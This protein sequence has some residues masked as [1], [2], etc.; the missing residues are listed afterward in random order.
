MP[1]D[2]HEK[3]NSLECRRDTKARRRI[4]DNPNTIINITAEEIEKGVTL[5]QLNEVNTEVH[6]YG[7]QLTIHGTMPD[8]NPNARVNGYKFLF[9]NG[10]GSIGVKY[11]AVDGDKK[12]IIAKVA[13]LVN[14]GWHTHLNSQGFELC[15]NFYVKDET[16]R[17]TAKDNTIAAMK[18]IP[19]D[20]FFGSIYAYTL[21]Y[22]MGYG[23]CADI[24]AIPE[25]EL[26]SFIS[27][28]FN[29]DETQVI[30]LERIQKEKEIA[31]NLAYKLQREI[32]IAAQK[33]K[34]EERSAR[35]KL[36]LPT[37]TGNKLTHI[38]RKTEITFCGYSSQ[39]E[40][41][42]PR[43]WDEKGEVI[44]NGGIPTGQ[45][46]KKIITIKKRGFKL[47]YAIGNDSYPKF[48]QIEPGHYD[49]WD[50]AC[51]AGQVFEV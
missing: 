34:D 12:A 6:C 24:G 47:C 16:Q 35:F 40:I 26:W 36:F 48:H 32:D 43:K 19:G 50:K 13:K 9:Q 51:A 11:G 46:E 21:M 42:T 49:K 18:S 17:Q 23:I 25:S 29:V 3:L 2:F 8:F 14:N 1:S 28:M 39:N 10:N 20:K 45:F 27:I 22:G 5:E 7:G 4:N 44:D 33:I 41:I 38:P 30:E 15:R 37:V 31:D